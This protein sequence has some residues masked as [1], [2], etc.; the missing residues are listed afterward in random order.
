MMLERKNA[1]DVVISTH[2]T[3]APVALGA[4]LL[5]VIKSEGFELV[6]LYAIPVEWKETNT[7]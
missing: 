7:F 1:V 6:R 3:T 4:P 2:A 5:I